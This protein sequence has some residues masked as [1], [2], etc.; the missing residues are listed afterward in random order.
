MKLRP[1][2][3]VARL[4]R[5]LILLQVVALSLVVIV[6]SIPEADRRGVPEL[7]EEILAVIAANLVVEGDGLVL[8]DQAGLGLRVRNYAGFWFLAGDARGHRAEFGPVPEPVRP[9]FRDI[10]TVVHAEFYRE[11]GGPEDS[12]IARRLDSP[13][14]RITLVSGGGPTLDPI[15][16]RLHRIDLSNVLFL[17]I[18]TIA[19]ALTI[20]W[21]LRRDLSG[22]SRVAEE[23]ARIDIDQPGARLT[24]ANVPP[25]LQ[26]MVGAM[27]A[28]LS[29][30]DEG[31]EKRKRFLATAAHELRTPIA[32]LTMRIELL[33][34]GSERGQLMLD[35]A[36]L[37]LLANQLLD[38]ERFDGGN[39]RL[40]RVDLNQL[41]GDAVMDIAPLAV[42]SGADLSFDAPDKPVEILADGQAILRV[43]ANL[44]QNA[45]AHGGGG[46]AIAVEVARPA[47]LRVRDNGRG[48]APEDR[49]QIFE[50][51]FRRSSASGS[52]LG[53]HLVQE[54][55]TRH[56]GT[57][58]ATEAVGGGAEFIV[59][60]PAASAKT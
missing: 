26:G 27:N 7:D 50:P 46:V 56:G 11:G 9:L 38:L 28:A 5:R 20:P 44:I 42:A 10:G 52:G 51:F 25:E 48:I 32:I 24:E 2:S 29:R 37:S 30:L 59:R 22:V 15:T 8:R 33:P 40:T 12:I 60:F 54:I 19:L 1:S 57:I 21:L 13:A 47:E 43:V 18:L 4:S 3:L 45:I 39:V 23:A 41:V 55:V 6:A 17:C 36:R 49:T 53:L 58:Q 31:M 34:P 16:G 35:V 14:G